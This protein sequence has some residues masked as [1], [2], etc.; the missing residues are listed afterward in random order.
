MKS[1][2]KGGGEEVVLSHLGFISNSE[3]KHNRHWASSQIQ[4]GNIIDIVDAR[5]ASETHI[6]EV[7]RVALVGGLCIQ[8]DENM[9][10]S[11]S[12]VVKIF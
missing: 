6:E 5:I 2:F 10:P 9:R 3:G 12:E 1:G 4:K 11:M 8:D 7:R